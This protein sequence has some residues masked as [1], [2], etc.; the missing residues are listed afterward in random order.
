MD[1][2]DW[3]YALALFVLTLAV[4]AA[5]SGGMLWRQSRAPHFVYQADALVRG[6]LH[7]TMPPPNLNDWVRLEDR[8]YVSF[9]P[10]PALLMAPFVAACGIGF[11]DVLFTLVF[12]ALNVPLLYALLRRFAAAGDEGA[13]GG[14]P[15]AEHGAH[16]LVFGFGTLAWYC[17]IRGEVWF[18][19]HTIGATLTLLYLH[20]AHHARRPLLAGTALACAAATRPP[21]AFAAVFFV[22]EALVGGGRLSPSTLTERLGD[23]TGRRDTF[24][25]L[26]LFVLPLALGAAAVAWM[27]VARFGDPF[28]FGHR[29]LYDNRVNA[30]IQMYG[31]FH[32]HFLARNLFDAF[33][34]LPEL[35]L[36]PFRLGF[37]GEG[38][39]V[40]VTTPL[41]VL[42]F[43]PRQSS[44]LHAPLWIT[45]AVIAIPGF[46]YQNSGWYQFGY[47]F[48]LDYTPYLVALLSLGRNPLTRIWWAL[49]TAGVVVNE[50]G[51]AVFN[52]AAE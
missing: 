39:S 48:S 23:P 41:F 31:L 33:L 20:A 26:V 51:A 3:R 49:A 5:S 4:Y 44:R 13:D 25:R 10:F 7:L 9:P 17:A 36:H 29:L 2:R 28:E 22:S 43:R 16:A 40:F 6:Q 8:W 37:S 21:L 24:R 15:P 11:N 45:A 47:R 30:Q 52:R 1:R 32:Y 34:R 38:M 27:N 35:H 19:A 46:L 12:G 14:R 18:T 42:L 50:W